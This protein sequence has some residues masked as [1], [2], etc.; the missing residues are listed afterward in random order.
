MQVR[1][2]RF[3]S[4]EIGMF[5]CPVCSGEYFLRWFRDEISKREAGI[6][7]LCQGCQDVVF[8]REEE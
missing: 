4:D 5:T 1:N 7:G 3:V 6:S 8:G 2:N